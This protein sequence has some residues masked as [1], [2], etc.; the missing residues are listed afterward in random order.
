MLDIYRQASR[1]GYRPTRF[2]EMLGEHGDVGTA[3]HLLAANKI[4]D[5]FA[6]LLLLGRP[7]LTVE[8]HVLQPGY[9]ELFNEAER[10]VARARLGIERT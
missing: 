9:A 3:H 4:H 6:E 1:L 5:G 7:D 2:R 10:D 8:H